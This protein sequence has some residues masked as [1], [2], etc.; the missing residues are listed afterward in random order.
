[1]RTPKAAAAVILA[2]AML[3]SACARF[4]ERPNE[5]IGALLGA[6]LGGFLGAQF[7][8]GKGKIIAA[9]VGVLA[10][11]WL[12]SEIGKKLDDADRKSV[13][14]LTQDALSHNPTGA[15]S[16]W[17]NP[18]TQVAAASAPTTDVYE[19][20]NGRDCR[21]F[22]QTVMLDGEAETITGTACR[23]GDGRWVVVE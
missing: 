19:A 18:E 22:E 10:G 5:T 7:G 15:V 17:E 2:A 6:G 13:A 3:T 20:P 4:E 9:S 16:K 11:A 8:G 14:G 1:M 21:D 12:G 23:D